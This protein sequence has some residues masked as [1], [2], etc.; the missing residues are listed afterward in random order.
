MVIE[1]V[2]LKDVVF[3]MICVLNVEDFIELSDFLFFEDLD[4]FLVD[5][6][7]DCENI[8]MRKLLK[9]RFIVIFV[10]FLNSKFIGKI[11]GLK[12]LLIKCYVIENIGNVCNIK[13]LSEFFEIK[14]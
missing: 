5:M 7:F 12:C 10:V 14:V 13:I 2:V 8:L 6:E 1:I 3:E 11:E 9:I 4:V